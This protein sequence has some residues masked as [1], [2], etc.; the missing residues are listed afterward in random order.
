[1]TREKDDR[2]TTATGGIETNNGMNDT[3]LIPLPGASHH[4]T[5]ERMDGGLFYFKEMPPT[6]AFKTTTTIPFD[7]WHKRL[8]HPS[9]EV[10]KLLP[11]VEVLKSSTQHLSVYETEILNISK[12]DVESQPNSPPQEL[13]NLDPDDQPMWE[14]ANTVA[15]TPNSIIVRPHVD[16]NFVINSTH[17]K[18][19]W[20]N[21]FDGYLRADPHDHIR[22]FLAICDIFKYDEST[23]RIMDETAKGILL[24]KS[25]NQAFQ[26][27]DDKVLF[28]LDWSTKSKNK[29]HQK[30]AALADESNS[31]DDNS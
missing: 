26:F 2:P 27:L 11:Q 25:P 29:H 30:S 16:D 23:Q 20:E 17:M 13:I 6:R 22:E 24:Y 28:K 21:K 18:I 14:S 3:N 5:G 19:I 8:G 10:L 4:M 31:N 15:L 7:L 1:M 9:L 12:E